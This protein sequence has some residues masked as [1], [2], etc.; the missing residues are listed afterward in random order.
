M[1]LIWCLL[2]SYDKDAL[3]YPF[4]IFDICNPKKWKKDPKGM[5]FVS[6]I[7]VFVLGAIKFKCIEKI[8][9]NS[10]NN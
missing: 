5:V 9:K 10:K 3:D 7:M 1:F 8:Q 4:I 2:F 6:L